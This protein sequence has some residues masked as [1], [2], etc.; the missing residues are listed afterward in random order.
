MDYRMVIA[1]SMEYHRVIACSME[2]HRVITCSMKYRMVIAC[3][4]EYR[5]VIACSMEYHRVIACSMEYH[6][7]IAC[8]MEY[9]MVIVCSMEYDRVI[10]R[11]MEYC[12]VISMEYH[13]VI[14][15]SMEYRRV[16]STEYR[17]AIV[18]ST[19]SSMGISPS[20]QSES[21][22]K[23]LDKR[24]AASDPETVK[25]GV[26]V[27]PLLPLPSPETSPVEVQ[28]WLQLLA[29]PLSD[30]SD[31]SGE[32]WMKIQELS[33]KAY[34]TWSKATP[35]ERLTLKAPRDRSLEEGRLAR[36]RA[37]AA[38]MILAAVDSTV[39]ADL[40]GRKSA[41]ST[42]QILYRILT[43]YQPGGENEKRF[44]IDQLTNPGSQDQ[45]SKAAESLRM[46]ESWYRRAVDVGVATPDATILS[47]ALMK[48]MEKVLQNPE[49]AFRTSLLRNS[50]KLDSRPT[51]ETI[52]ALHKHLL[53]EAEG[54]ST[55]TSRTTAT[56]ATAQDKSPK[57]KGLQTAGGGDTA[58][59]PKAKSAPSSSESTTQR[60][61]KWF[62]KSDTGCRRGSECQF[63]HEWGSTPKAGRCLLCSAV[64][65]GKKDCPTKDKSAGTTGNRQRGEASTS[66]SSVPA[67][68]NKAL[69]AAVDNAPTSPASPQPATEPSPVNSPTARSRPPEEDYPEALKKIMDDAQKV[70]KSLMASSSATPTSASAFIPTYESIQK[71]LDGDVKGWPWLW[72][73]LLPGS[74][75]EQGDDGG[76]IG[77]VDLDDI[78]PSLPGDGG[79][80]DPPALKKLSADDL[81]NDDDVAEEQQK[82]DVEKEPLLE[83][84]REIPMDHLYF[85]M[86]L[87]SKKSRVVMQAIQEI[88]LQ[89]K[90]ENL[91]VVRIHSD[92]THELRSPGLRE[93]A[94]DQG[95]MLTRAEGQSPQSN[96]TAERAV[97]YL[98]GKALQGD[99][100]GQG[101]SKLVQEI[102][103]LMAKDP[104]YNVK[105][106]QA[107]GG[108]EL[109]TNSVFGITKYT[110]EAAT[111]A[112]KVAELL[113]RDFP[114][115]CF[116]SATVIQNTVMPTH[117]DVFND[118][119]S[120]NLIFPLKTTRGAGVWEEMKP[121]DVFK[122]K[123][124][125]M[126]IKEK[127]FSGQVHLLTEPVSVNPE[128]WHCAVQGSEGPRLLVAGH[129]IGS[130]RKLIPEINQKLENLGF[131]LPEQPED[132][133]Q[134]KAI[135]EGGYA[136]VVDESD[137]IP[138]YENI[139]GIAEVE[140][141]VARCA[142]AAAENLY[143]PGIEKLL[144]ELDGELR[145]VHT[146]HPAEVEKSLPE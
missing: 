59:N 50:L 43:L 47:R 20:H 109:S 4:M 101:R 102:L 13:R 72:I 90:H 23:A 51:Q 95:I 14:A 124:Q 32:W 67:V 103:E 31:S 132:E 85:M 18:I 145:V 120:R 73:P 2:Y 57:I 114:G 48:T 93:W 71:Q 82:K 135:Q 91:P 62:A 94:L 97:R 41:Q 77:D 34:V 104:V 78:E 134:F 123:H 56:A 30:L 49:A 69:A 38:S 33:Q 88:V 133:V 5:M 6:R 129:T 83:G 111:L 128:R 136:Y 29:A 68:A 89:L 39:K 87:K 24:G 140:T 117:K 79:E 16:I 9:R 84:N 15:R 96:G 105:R 125:E 110:D 27:L 116:T 118:F 11:S 7:V 81:W 122:G 75:N 112:K 119:N 26:T 138:D 8:S 52:L 63:T 46:W 28:D 61:C 45:A 126:Q 139:D 100:G 3:S 80:D 40:V 10:A 144:S 42:S 55:S 106:P 17:R 36:L 65:H 74:G 127:T 53:A 92:R 143:T 64:G 98:K 146:V 58:P 113:R 108:A 37:R 107:A 60:A 35:L 99:T 54:L 76:G 25:P 137:A 141:D 19:E 131:A 22:A 21:Q 86:S 115:E 44:V 142:K 121:G 70:L 1:C 130:W 12:R 66:S